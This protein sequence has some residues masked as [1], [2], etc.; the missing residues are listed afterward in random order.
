MFFLS[1]FFFSS[2]SF[3]L[4]FFLLCFLSF[5]IWIFL[6]VCRF[7][8][9][10]LLSVCHF[11]FFLSIFY[12]PGTDKDVSVNYL[13]MKEKSIA[14]YRTWSDFFPTLYCH[15]FNYLYQNRKS[16]ERMQM[17]RKYKHSFFFFLFSSFLSFSLPFIH[18]SF[19]H[20][21]L[22]FSFFFIPLFIALILIFILFSFI[23]YHPSFCLLL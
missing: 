23:L 5:T 3:H 19:I 17:D 16:S 22:S 12:P 20:S 9:L 2:F 1:S 18:S 14:I 6:L 4:C 15:D 13:F 8:F 7:F 10:C 21:F 11:L